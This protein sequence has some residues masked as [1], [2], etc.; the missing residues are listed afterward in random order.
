MRLG[1]MPFL[2]VYIRVLVLLFLFDRSFPRLIRLLGIF[3]IS[4]LP[5]IVVRLFFAHRHL[6]VTEQPGGP[7]AVPCG[8]N[9]WISLGATPAATAVGDQRAKPK[10]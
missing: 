4:L 9:L 6:P 5:G 7:G 1:F 2:E 8:A 3:P 10:F